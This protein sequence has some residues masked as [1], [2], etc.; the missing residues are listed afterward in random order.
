MGD[1]NISVMGPLDPLTR[2]FRDV[3]NW[4]VNFPTRVTA[5]SSA[6]IGNEITNVPDSTGYVVSTAVSYHFAPEIMVHG[7]KTEGQH[8]TSQCS[9]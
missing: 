4:P 5:T 2:R 8:S 6:G 9:R 7:Y 1:Y 3:L